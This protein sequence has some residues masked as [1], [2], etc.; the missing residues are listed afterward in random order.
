MFGVLAKERRITAMIDDKIGS[1]AIPTRRRRFLRDVTVR[2]VAILLGK[3]SLWVLG[4]V[5]AL[6]LGTSAVVAVLHH[7]PAAIP[8]STGVVITKLARIGQFHAARASFDFD[9]PYVV[10]RSFLFL[11]GETIT[12]D[13]R[14]TDDAVVNFAGLH[15]AQVVRPS[16]TSVSILLPSPRLGTP[17]IDLGATTMSESG[18][19]FT[20]I[21]HLVSS[22]PDDARQALANAQDKIAAQAADSDLVSQAE[23][24]TRA[25][26]VTLLTKLGFKH[27]AVVFM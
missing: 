4:L 11:T 23:S 13:G 15:P 14:G 21:S 18:G 3:L 9:F 22:D 10:H 5:L 27:I 26:L 12:L 24:S 20:H 17:V 2:L 1:S 6:V 25:F 16:P 19:L 8:V 7:R